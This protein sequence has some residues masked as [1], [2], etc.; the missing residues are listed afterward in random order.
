MKVLQGQGVSRGV[1]GGHLV[2]LPT[3]EKPPLKKPTGSPAKEWERYR[4]ARDT[5]L[6]ELSDLHLQTQSTLGADN[7]AVFEIHRMLLQDEDFNALVSQAIN[8]QRHGAEYAVYATCSILSDAFDQLD[9]EYMRARKADI[10]DISMR[11][12][13]VLEGAEDFSLNTAQPVVVAAHDLQPS[14]TAQLNP[15]QVVAFVT[16]AGSATS[17]TAIF[18]RTL[19]IPAVVHLK[20]QL[21]QDKVAAG[22]TIY[23]DGDVGAVYVNPDA[24]TTRRLE[25]KQTAHREHAERLRRLVGQPTRTKNGVAVKL[26]ANVGGVADVAKV[27]AADAEG[28]GLFRSEFIYLQQPSLPDEAT[29]FAAYKAVLEAMQNKPVVVRTLDLGADKQTDYYTLPHQANP[30]LG[31][32]GVRLSL[33]HPAVFKTQLRAILR[34][35]VHGNLRL[36]LPLITSVQEVLDAQ[37]ILSD[38]KNELTQE[39][40]PFNEAVPLGIMIETPAAAMI[41]DLLAPHVDFFSIGSNDLT[42]YTLAMDRESTLLEPFYNSRH[43]ALLRLMERTVQSAKAAGIPVG[44]CG[45]LA[46]DETMLSAFLAMGLRE[47]SVVPSAVLPLRAAIAELTV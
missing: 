18:A 22:S 45:E 8:E 34:A 12:I 30:A 14:Q 3:M 36:M 20:D 6:Q 24:A 44:V 42:Q 32:R 16:S 1:A 9:D 27:L 15:E 37:V 31:L 29:Q 5:A 40:V 7:A 43:P 21:S 2:Y 33:T 19:G 26:Y 23:V 10:T 38:V 39:G 28:I 46:A 41:S 35:S 17:H 4:K 47:F 13:R 25:E 11:V